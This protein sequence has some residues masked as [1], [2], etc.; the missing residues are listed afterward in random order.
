MMTAPAMS[1][2]TP[3]TTPPFVSVRDTLMFDREISS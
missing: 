2:P 3:T 1:L